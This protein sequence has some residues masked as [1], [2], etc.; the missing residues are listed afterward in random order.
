MITMPE[1]LR[2]RVELRVR[3]R[4]ADLK[5]RLALQLPSGIRAEAE[6]EGIVLR[7]RGLRRRFAL[8]AGL[9]WLIPS[10]SGVDE[11]TDR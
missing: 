3:R 11:E 5:E 2:V 7:G 9:K 6:P 8:E 4:V 1:S 10:L